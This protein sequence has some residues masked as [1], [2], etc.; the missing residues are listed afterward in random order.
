MLS[1]SGNDILAL[2]GG[3]DSEAGGA[4]VVALKIWREPV[5]VPSVLVLI[6]GGTVV[7]TPAARIARRTSFSSMATSLIVW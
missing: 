4:L 2:E 7:S 1:D 6:D 3:V 5:S